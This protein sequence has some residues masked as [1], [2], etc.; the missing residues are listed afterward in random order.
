MSGAINEDLAAYICAHTNCFCIADVS[1]HETALIPGGGGRVSE[2]QDNTEIL[3][4]TFGPKWKKVMEASQDD[5][6]K[7]EEMG[8]AWST[9]G[10]DNKFIKNYL[11]ILKGRCHV[12][13][14][15]IDGRI[16]LEN[17]S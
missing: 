3:S 12:G 4:R 9:R 11:E 6:V 7:E 13:D 16:L 15:G 10:K 14:L 17:V 5:Q 1:S 8:G 2:E